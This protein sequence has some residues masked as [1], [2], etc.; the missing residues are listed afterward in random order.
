MTQYEMQHRIGVSIVSEPYLIPT[1]NSWISNARGTCA[2]HW[3]YHNTDSFGTLFD[4]GRYCVA[5]ESREFNVIACYISPNA[6]DAKYSRFLNE[7]D[8]M[9]VKL[10]SRRT[11]I[12]GDFN[13]KDKMWGAR[14]TDSRGEKITRWAASRDLRLLNEGSTPTCVRHQGSS[15]VDLTWSTADIHSRINDWKVLE[16]FTFSDHMYISFQLHMGRNVDND[17]NIVNI[18]NILN[19]NPN[20]DSIYDMYKKKEYARWSH[21]KLDSDLFSETLEWE[22][23]NC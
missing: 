2:I 19:A 13:A 7:I 6:D 3:N 20:R 22:C 21:K 23:L 12:A 8:S 14:V 17:V 15:I 11:I 1:D 9:Y 16:D 4:K 18:P 5:V 10:K